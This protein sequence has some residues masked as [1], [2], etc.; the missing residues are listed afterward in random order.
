L[1]LFSALT[2]TIARAQ[3]P[4]TQP[5]IGLIRS[6][7]EKGDVDAQLALGIMY[8]QGKGVDQD[9]GQAIRWYRAAA[10]HGSSAAL[11]Q[12]GLAYQEGNGVPSVMALK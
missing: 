6:L 10:S 9:F 12:I 5:S 7:A 11:Y 2:S 8:A 4:T 1:I 3:G